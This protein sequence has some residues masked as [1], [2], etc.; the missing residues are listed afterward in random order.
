MRILQHPELEVIDEEKLP[1]QRR[2]AV[3]EL[4][5]SVFLCPKIRMGCLFKVSETRL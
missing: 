1:L 3:S 4:S 5:K 2:R